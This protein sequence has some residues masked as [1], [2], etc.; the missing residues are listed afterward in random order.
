MITASQYIAG[1]LYEGDAYS[2]QSCPDTQM[3]MTVTSGQYSCACAAAYTLVGVS[4]IGEQSC[5]L[6]TLTEANKNDVAQASQV[7]YYDSRAAGN[8]G[9]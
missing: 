8:Y 1:K 7:T 6:T 3:S 4:G 2:C 5:V 9:L